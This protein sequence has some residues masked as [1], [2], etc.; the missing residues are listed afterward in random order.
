[1]SR[2]DPDDRP[3]EERM[4]AVAEWLTERHLP[5]HLRERGFHIHWAPEPQEPRET[6][7]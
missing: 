3:L 4:A 7:R 5:D 2:D 1:M 6:D